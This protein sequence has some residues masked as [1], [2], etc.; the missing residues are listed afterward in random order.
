MIA[1]P[2]FDP[3]SFS[4]AVRSLSERERDPGSTRVLFEAAARAN[5]A[6]A[7]RIMAGLGLRGCTARCF[8][9]RNMAAAAPHLLTE[10]LGLRPERFEP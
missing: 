4:G 2:G 5:H 6:P 7:V 3:H 1:G 8:S 9:N 10:L